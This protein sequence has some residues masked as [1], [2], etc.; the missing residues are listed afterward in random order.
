MKFNSAVKG[1]Q[2]L[3]AEVENPLGMNGKKP[4]STIGIPLPTEGKTK[5]RPTKLT[6]ERLELT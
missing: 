5:F 6:M 4:P 1:I 3:L 2:E